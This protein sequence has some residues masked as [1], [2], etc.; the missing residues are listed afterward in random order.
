S[1]TTTAP[2]PEPPCAIR[3]LLTPD[4]ELGMRGLGTALGRSGAPETADGLGLAAIAPFG[5][6]ARPFSHVFP[7]PIS[8]SQLAL[9]NPPSLFCTVYAASRKYMV[10]VG[11]R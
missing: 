11:G 7:V 3:R 8:H 10:S 6:G 2:R 1:S 5:R 4:H 9:Y